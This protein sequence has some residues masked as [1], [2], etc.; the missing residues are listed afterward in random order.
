[1]NMEVINP[2]FTRDKMPKD[3]ALAVKDIKLAIL[4][5]MVKAARLANAIYALAHGILEWNV[6]DECCYSPCLLNEKVE[7]V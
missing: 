1:M 6:P 4:Q 3:F 5:A 7:Y 2:N